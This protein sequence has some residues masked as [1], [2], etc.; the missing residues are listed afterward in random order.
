M[1]RCFYTSELEVQVA[2]SMHAEVRRHLCMLWERAGGVACMHAGS[3][4]SALVWQCRSPA[5]DPVPAHWGPQA[6]EER[7]D[8]VGH[9]AHVGC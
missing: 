4:P 5:L 2:R 7:L 8:E 3:S 9:T 1:G 6:A